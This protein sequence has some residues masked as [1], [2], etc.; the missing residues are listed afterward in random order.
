MKQQ[1]RMSRR[2]QG[3]HDCIIHNFS[4]LQL[5]MFLENLAKTIKIMKMRDKNEQIWRNK[6][7]RTIVLYL[8][9]KG[10]DCL[11][12]YRQENMPI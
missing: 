6:K 11:E 2:I 12:L 8:I 1:V 7:S 9:T 4:Q 3:V 10:F 5:V